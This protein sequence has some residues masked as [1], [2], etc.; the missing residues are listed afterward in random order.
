MQVGGVVAE[1]VA[2][3]E[4]GVLR[5]EGQVGRG[6]AVDEDAQR[7]AQPAAVGR[8]GDRVPQVDGVGRP[9]QDEVDVLARSAECHRGA[10]DGLGGQ[11]V[12]V[13]RRA[14]HGAVG[15][16]PGGRVFGE[17]DAG[18]AAAVGGRHHR[19]VAGCRCWRGACS[20][21]PSGACQ[22]YERGKNHARGEASCE[23]GP[24]PSMDSMKRGDLDV[25]TFPAFIRSCNTDAT[26]LAMN[27][28]II[29]GF[30]QFLASFRRWHA[31]SRKRPMR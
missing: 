24:P 7:R 23:H 14:D 8:V 20:S 29:A 15:R 11:R 12:E 16:R 27:S 13:V 10:A 5:G 18:T 30:L 22:C 31:A 3:V 21:Y 26:V 25:R 17:P 28:L 4:P 1:R 2:A 6:P 19:A 9:G